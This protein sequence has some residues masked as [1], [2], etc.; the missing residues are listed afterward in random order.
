MSPA[1]ISR[2]GLWPASGIP[3]RNP[4]SAISGSSLASSKP[5][6]CGAPGVHSTSRPWGAASRRRPP[7]ASP[8]T[9][10]STSF[11]REASAGARRSGRPNSSS[12]TSTGTTSWSSRRA[13]RTAPFSVSGSACGRLL[14]LPLRDGGAQAPEL[15]LGR[16]ADLQMARLRREPLQ[17][18]DVLA[19]SHAAHEDLAN[20]AVGGVVLQKAHVPD[21]LCGL[22]ANEEVPGAPHH[23]DESPVGGRAD[24]RRFDPVEELIV[25][26]R[27]P[28]APPGRPR[29]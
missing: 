21:L 24:G 28:A 13:T 20:V 19:A 27:H 29:A 1:R 17:V 26:Q 25:V 10:S 22:L 4:S 2:S 12:P 16:F 23:L 5:M 9:A 15:S 6:R 11:S 3:P 14:P 18:L 8:A 7:P